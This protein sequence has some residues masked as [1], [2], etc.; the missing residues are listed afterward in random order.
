M[1]LENELER[2]LQSSGRLEQV[3]TLIRAGVNV[4]HILEAG[5]TFLNFAVIHNRLDIVKVLV[6]AGAEVNPVRLPSSDEY[7]EFDEHLFQCEEENSTSCPLGIAA[8]HGFQ[9]IFDFLAPL[10][11]PKERRLATIDLPNG[12]RQRA[13]IEEWRDDFTQVSTKK[14]LQ[15]VQ[16]LI[17]AGSDINE[18]AQNGCTIL[19]TAA[20]NGYIES[21]RTLI[22]TDAQVN[23]KNRTDGWSPLMIA[24]ATHEAW[25]FGTQQFWGENRSKQIEVVSLLLE[26][27]AN[28]NAAAYDG[29]TPLMEAVAFETI[30]MVELLLGAGSDVNAREQS[31]RN[32]L[33]AY[34]AFKAEQV[35]SPCWGL[36]KD[37]ERQVQIV[38]LLIEAGA[39]VNATTDEGRT[40]LMAAATS[41]NPLMVE[42]LLQA[43]A[44]LDLRDD[45]GKNALNYAQDALQYVIDETAQN[46]ILRLLQNV[47]AT[48]D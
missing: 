48:E 14:H 45:A 5:F 38:R 16:D 29:R 11:T 25:S 27:G 20:H 28:I 32:V 42:T 44:Q 19:W 30:D 3:E 31:G 46:E 2:E 10:T 22:N 7:S 8:G 17:A 13:R 24:A 39:D 35:A 23:I 41:C 18:I 43:G 1:S 47:G 36:P 33:H 34:C 12:I 26:A 21:V 37:F 40:P 4:N 15:A 6:E 9:E